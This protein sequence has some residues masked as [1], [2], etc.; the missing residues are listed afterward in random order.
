MKGSL[1]LLLL[2]LFGSAI[3]SSHT[4]LASSKHV[5]RTYEYFTKWSHSEGHS[6][7]APPPVKLQRLSLWADETNEVHL[8]T[9]SPQDTPFAVHTS[10]SHEVSAIYFPKGAINKDYFKGLAS[11]FIF[12]E[13]P[14]SGWERDV[15][16][17]CYV[18]YSSE[19]A[20]RRIRKEKKECLSEETIRHKLHDDRSLFAWSSSSVLELNKAERALTKASVKER[21]TKRELNK[22][23]FI[24]EAEMDIKLIEENIVD[25]ILSQSKATKVEEVI[26]ILNSIYKTEF[27][28]EDI[29]SRPSSIRKFKAT[30][31]VVLKKSLKANNLATPEGAKAFMTA[32]KL[33]K[34]ADEKAIITLLKDKSNKNILPQLMDIL[35]ACHTTNA[36]KA[37]LSIFKPSNGVN[38]KL[39]ERFIWALSSMESYWTP[40]SHHNEY[41]A[42]EL[43]NHLKDSKFA[44]DSLKQSF[45]LSLSLITNNIKS[46]EEYLLWFVSTLKKCTENDC[47]AQ[48][49][50][51]LTNIE[52]SSQEAL[53]Q[54]VLSLVKDFIKS[55]TS[56]KRLRINAIKLAKA[57]S[58]DLSE[59]LQSIFLTVF[60]NPAE[61]NSLRI[62]IAE[63]LLSAKFDLQIV[64]LLL[65]NLSSNPELTSYL[66]NKLNSH[67]KMKFIQ[68]DLMT[69]GHWNWNLLSS[70]GQSL[71]YLDEGE[72]FSTDFGLEVSSSKIL[73]QSHLHINLPNVTDFLKM[74]LSTGGLSGFIA[75]TPDPTDDPNAHLSVELSLLS[76]PL[77]TFTVFSSMSELTSLYWS[78]A[79]ENKQSLLG[80]NRFVY[81]SVSIHVFSNGLRLESL[82]EGAVSMD[83]SGSIVVSLFS[84]T[85]DSDMTSGFG[86]YVKRSIIGH[87]K[88]KVHFSNIHEGTGKFALDLDGDIR[89]DGRSCVQ[90]LMQPVKL[91]E[92]TTKTILDITTNKSTSSGDSNYISLPGR[93]LSLHQKISQLCNEVSA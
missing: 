58:P 34:N 53:G 47:R 12:R 59:G 24:V 71:S 14:W 63:Q 6:H 56:S 11:L 39:L 20:E 22:E 82:L 50:K 60:M 51:A 38:I 65:Q 88:D 21:F 36:F 90:L 84:Q 74:E 42:S 52:Y 3:L 61:D 86:G 28:G 32:V 37:V 83:I 68:Y 92:K 43:F 40:Q 62:L 44:T 2:F 85:A 55:D 57:I 66:V 49:L 10:H 8:Y 48:A 41:I 5:E 78:G 93:T 18:V 77:R 72:Y 13:E 4:G 81:N 70:G 26:G 35:G 30:D 17:D 80:F 27:V 75:S 69:T 46:N 25:D 89:F 54:D 87:W 45:T 16:G 29:R 64:I 7:P 76:V 19:G 91:K 31:L 73:R 23:D 9:L 67:P 15:S 1:Y 79:L 33:L